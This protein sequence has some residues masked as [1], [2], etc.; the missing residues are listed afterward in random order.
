MNENKVKKTYV[1]PTTEIVD[2]NNELP[3]LCGSTPDTGPDM[4]D[5]G[6]WG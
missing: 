1:K 6:T 4:G 5:C 3:I 2:L